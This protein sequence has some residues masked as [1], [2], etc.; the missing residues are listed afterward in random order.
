MVRE[1]YQLVTRHN[2][3]L[4]LNLNLHFTLYVLLLLLVSCNGDQVPDCLQNAGELRR[5]EVSVADFDKI[6][7]YELVRVVVQ[8][9]PEQRV[10][11]ETGEFLRGEVTAVVRDGRLELRNSNNCNLFRDYGQTTFYITTPELV[12]IRSSTGYPI[13]S[14]GSLPFND[15][16]LYSESFLDPGALT[17]DGSFDLELNSENV[18]VV[19][20]GIAYF[21]LRGVTANLRLSIAAGDSR[22]EAEE[23]LAQHVTINHRGS[24]DMLVYPVQSLR[25]V[26]RGTGDV[27]SYH[28]PDTVDVEQIYRGRLVFPD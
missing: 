9:G 24:N 23:L 18:S 22:I 14:D 19:A 2:L 3:N 20:N 6:T 17:T 15:L 25:G 13:V 1:R 16:S 8:Y 11:V 7:A 10:E 12:E 27:L 5:E 26:I 28:N 4:H 21:K